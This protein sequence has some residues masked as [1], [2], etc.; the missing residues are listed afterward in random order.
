[1]EPQ[2]FPVEDLKVQDGATP[3]TI[4]FTQPVNP[5]T[6]AANQACLRKKSVPVT[7]TSIV[8]EVEAPCSSSIV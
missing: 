6:F 2:N 7:V 5:A 8:D 4:R 3:I 1:M